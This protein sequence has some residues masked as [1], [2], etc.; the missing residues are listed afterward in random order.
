MLADWSNK[1][2]LIVVRTYPTPATKGIEVSCTAGVTRDGKWIRLF[3]VPYRFLEEDQRFAKCQWIN[4]SVRRA[5]SDQRP[6]SY[7]LNADTIRIVKSLP[8]GKDWRARSDILKPLRRPSLCE[9]QQYRDDYGAPTLGI[10]RPGKIKRL[11]IEPTETPDW[12][13]RDLEILN[14]VNQSTLDLGGTTPKT[15]LEKVPWEFRYDFDCDDPTCNGHS[16][17][18]T[19]WEMAQS[20]R[21]WRRTYGDSGWQAK[22]RERYE[23]DM[24]ERF[25]TSFFVGTLHQYPAN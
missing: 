13:P 20:Y 4:V 5:R 3:P 19:D 14:R 25:D 11:R 17:M 15:R 21:A 2:V 22:F 1:D 18:C 8:P 12:Q 6:E 9:I 10:F 23:R 7:N 24:I 16:M